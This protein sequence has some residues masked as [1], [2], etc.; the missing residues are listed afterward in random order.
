MTLARILAH[1]CALLTP[2]VVTLPPGDT[3]LSGPIVLA[4]RVKLRGAW[5]VGSLATGHD[6]VERFAPEALDDDGLHLGS[7]IK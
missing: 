7:V 1:C 3:V 6:G 4:G 5:S 2:A